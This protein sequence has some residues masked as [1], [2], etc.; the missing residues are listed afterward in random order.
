MAEHRPCPRSAAASRAMRTQTIT[1]AVDS[2]MGTPSSSSTPG[3][4]TSS[5][6]SKR[7]SSGPETRRGVEELLGVPMGEST[8]DV[9]VR[10]RIA[11]DA[12]AARGH[13]LSSAIPGPL[14][15]DVAPL[16]KAARL[17]LRRELEADR[18]SGRGLHRVRRVA[19][20]LADLR[21][22]HG[23]IDEEWVSTALNLR[24]D[25]LEHARRAA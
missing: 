23:E 21:G 8:A 17:V 3:R 12:A 24:I 13:G 7:S 19:R 6:R 16:T 11:R 2:P 14:L 9:M 10:V 22:C 25:P 18:L 1:S 5:R 4:A 15:D 20:T